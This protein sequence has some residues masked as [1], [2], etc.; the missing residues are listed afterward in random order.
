[1]ATIQEPARE[2]PVSG[3]YDVVV[4][5]GGPAG[6]AAAV[7]AARAGAR[8]LLAEQYGSLGGIWTTG[9]LSY[10]LDWAN[11]PGLM[12]EIVGRLEARGARAVDSRGRGTNAFDPEQVRFLLDE[13]CLEAGVT[14]QLHSRVV[15]A[16]VAGG[17]LT[18]AVI[19]S[20]SGREAVAGRQ[21]I[22]CTGNGDLGA[23]AGCGFDMGH[24]QT[25]ATQPM[26][27]I[28]LLTGLCRDEV[29]P[30]FYEQGDAWS[31]PKDR[32]REAMERGGCSPSYAKPSLFPLREDLFLLMANHEYG[33]R[34]TDVRD[35]TAATLHARR[36]LH[37]LV[38]ALRSLGGPWARVRVAATGA[39]IGV[40]E[41]RRIHGR[42]TVTVE[43][44]AA[45]RQYPDA[46]CR[47]TFGIDVH[48][49]DPG[50]GKGIEPSPVKTRPYEIPL[51]A[52]QAR[53]VEGLWMAGRCISGDFLA[54]SSYRVTGNAVAMGETA[55][56]AAA[57][58]AAK[59]P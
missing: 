1:M 41:G 59:M 52:L 23:I 39:Q 44:M 49:T 34:G 19:E 27:L 32:L 6:V 40:R 35:L 37:A 43:D 13:L 30:F 10:F 57:R 25:G 33:Y 14:L 55:G 5:G 29:R 3:V 54:H 47:V 28:A 7:A 36:E 8:C 4:C 2:T 51:G 45:G 56:A 18:H 31:A 26:S 15:A 16:R 22:D 12:A 38:A 21:F 48:S 24:P 17:V 58:A 46:A 42:S 11:K 53:D 9:L 20:P 50:A